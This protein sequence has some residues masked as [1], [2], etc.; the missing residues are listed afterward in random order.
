L[1][2]DCGNLIGWVRKVKLNVVVV[3]CAVMGL[4][5]WEVFL[6]DAG[7]FFCL[8]RFR[9]VIWC[10]LRVRLREPF[11][12]ELDRASVAFGGRRVGISCEVIDLGLHLGHHFIKLSALEHPLQLLDL[13]D[14]PSRDPALRPLLDG[15]NCPND[16]CLYLSPLILQ[17]LKFLL[18]LDLIS[19]ELG[20]EL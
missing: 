7:V 14:L 17:S 11:L 1:D 19:S 20:L 2:L 5:F 10:W 6:P 8:V 3:V 4:L 13:L 9:L 16:D 12:S 15:N 18:H